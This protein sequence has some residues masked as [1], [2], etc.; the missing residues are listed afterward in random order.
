MQHESDEQ[1]GNNQRHPVKKGDRTK[2]F[3]EIGNS[4]KVFINQQEL[5]EAAIQH[6]KTFKTVRNQHPIHHE[7]EI[8]DFSLNARGTEE[9]EVYVK[10]PFYRAN[11]RRGNTFLYN[12]VEKKGEIARKGL[13]KFFDISQSSLKAIK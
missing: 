3:R 13:M 1:K 8:V 7:F 12:K 11:I 4:N 6:S 5:Y 2:E 9:D 10:Y